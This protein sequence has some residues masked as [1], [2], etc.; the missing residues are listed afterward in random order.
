[1]TRSEKSVSI[2]LVVLPFVDWLLPCFL[3]HIHPV[4]E[5]VPVCFFYEVD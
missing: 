3:S 2:V 4:S 5:G 1:M